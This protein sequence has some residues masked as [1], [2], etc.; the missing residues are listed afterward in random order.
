ML[1]VLDV[2]GLLV[3][4]MYIEKISKEKIEELENTNDEAVFKSGNFYVQVRE[5]LTMFFEKLFRE[6]VVSVWTSS[7]YKTVRPILEN[8]LTEDQ[9]E[10]LKFI[11]CRDR[12]ELDPEYG[13]P[14]FP[15][16]KS[17]STVKKLK[18]VLASPYVNYDREW[19]WSNVIIIDDG[20]EKVRY[21]PKENV[22]VWEDFH[23]DINEIWEEIDRMEDNLSS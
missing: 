22:L 21:N 15:L 3:N 5:N 4:K 19:N 17:H 20:E 18:R 2:D 1:V 11:W 16:L 10:S 8:I 7:N 9:L 13:N 14:E 23:R 12:T 6:H